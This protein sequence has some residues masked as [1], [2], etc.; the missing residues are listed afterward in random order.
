MVKASNSKIL[1]TFLDDTKNFSKKESDVEMLGVAFDLSTSY[2]GGAWFGPYAIVDASYQ[3][4][5]EVPHFKT[6]LTDK[7]KIH[8]LGVLEY[9]QKAKKI[10][11]VSKEMV[12]DV[13]RES[14]NA[15]KENKFLMTLGGDHS[16]PNGVFEAL[17]EKFGAKNV[18]IIHFDAHT[19]LWKNFHGNKYS[20]AS[21]MSNAI[22]LGFPTIHI[23]IRD[24]LGEDFEL[25]E[26]HNLAK[27]T[28]FCASQ[29]KKFYK[30]HGIPTENFVFNGEISLNLII[31]MLSKIRTP[32]AYISLDIDVLD[33]SIIQG[34]GTPMPHGLSLKSLEN[35]LHRIISFC[36]KAD[37]KL[38]GFDLVEVSPQLRKTGDYYDANNAI[39]T[40]TEMIAALIAYKILF[41]QYLERF[42]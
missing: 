34:T 23:G 39:N 4:N 12:K 13:K 18:T 33:S 22:E 3:V 11:P 7:V 36:K 40:S 42:K 21:I 41:W 9:P 14:L 28:F 38:L 20:H 6:K 10:I 15:L 19:D 16:I 30:T 2:S 17:N 35:C 27:D 1:G 29:P 24:H 25:F 5:Y 32:F 8:S 31:K 37:V 26:K